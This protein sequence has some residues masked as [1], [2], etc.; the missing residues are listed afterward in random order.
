MDI[1]LLN[2]KITV[3]KNETVVDAIGNHKNT[4]TDYH[5]CF[6]T[7]SGEGGSEKSVAGLIVDDSDIS[8]TVR[9]CKAF[10]DLDVTK[11]RV[12]FETTLEKA[13]KTSE[14]AEDDDAYKKVKKNID[15]AI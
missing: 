9:Y 8:F 3:Q 12:I 14:E 5:T 4:W 15:N 13:V 1:A 11:H 7:V 2:V 6:A 10:A